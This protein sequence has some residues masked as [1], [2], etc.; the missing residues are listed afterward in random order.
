MVDSLYYIIDIIFVVNLG[1][2]GRV[3][4]FFPGLRKIFYFSHMKTGNVLKALLSSH[5]SSSKIRLLYN[6]HSFNQK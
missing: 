5:N 1:G 4:D 6:K 3:F 2:Q